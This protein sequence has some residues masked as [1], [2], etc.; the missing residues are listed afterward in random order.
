[1]SE[2]ELDFE[3]HEIECPHCRETIV[4]LWPGSLILYSETSCT[5]CGREFLIVQNEPR[6]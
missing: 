1:M 4:R 3:K 5:Q 2:I 6:L